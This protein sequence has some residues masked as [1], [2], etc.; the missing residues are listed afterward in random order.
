MN[1]AF[2]QDEQALE[3]LNNVR[4]LVLQTP[5]GPMTEI[6]GGRR[7]VD[8]SQFRPRGHYDDSAEL[9]R[10]FRCLMWL[11]RADYAWYV[12][13]AQP[14]DA[15]QVDTDRELRAAVRLARLLESTGQ[16]EELRAIDAALAFLVGRGDDLS[17]AELLGVLRAGQIR[18]TEAGDLVRL[19]DALKSGDLARPMIRSQVLTSPSDPS[20]QAEAPAAFQVLGQR[21]VLDSFLLSRFVHDAIEYRGQK[22]LRY[23]PR[24][25]DVMAALGNDEAVALLE[26]EI[27]RWGYAANVM[28]AR[29]FVARRPA[30]AW[31][32]AVSDLWLDAL[33]TLD[34]VPAA[35]ASVPEAMQTRAWRRKQLQAQLGSWAELRHDT[36]LYAK[37]SYT[38]LGCEYPSG[39]VE[40]YPRF[41]AK[42]R[43]LAEEAGR[44]LAAVRPPSRDSAVA[45]AFLQKNQARLD[46]FANMA[47]TAGRLEAMAQKELDGQPFTAEEVAFLKKTIDRR[48][49]GS[50]PP[51]FDGWYSNLFYS[52]FDHDHWRATVADVHTD[53]NSGEALQAATG[54]TGL[55]VVAVDSQGDRA[56]YVGPSYSYYEFRRPVD[57]RLTDAEWMAMIHRRE[58]P[59][60][61]EW[62]RSFRAP[63]REPGRG[64]PSYQP[65]IEKPNWDGPVPPPGARPAVRLP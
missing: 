17:P 52:P 25:L 3:I 5:P 33:R 4:A 23:M 35:G 50:G 59:D 16:I 53:P 60:A 22:M 63:P 57:S 51:R 32:E 49:T 43:R 14:S 24:G 12:L 2:R 64:L 54:N 56:V 41:F 21:F 47:R 13:P 29:D 26:G 6:Y 30:G 65:A 55:L 36:V 39:Y 31:S 44:Q 34:D 20:A 7:C 18:S 19:K 46:F 1:S 45:Q 8:Y 11:G 42:I 40:P 62:A 15:L 61:P 9:R 38:V 28:A 37:Q 48:G 58:L 10:Y 27:R